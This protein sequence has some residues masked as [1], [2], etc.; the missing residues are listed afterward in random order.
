MEPDGRGSHWF[1]VSS[2]LREKSRAALGQAVSFDI[3]F[4]DEWAEPSIP[5]D[6]M[7]AIV[8][9]GLAGQWSTITTKAR[10]EWL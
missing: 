9:V 3:E 2:E 4:A 10:W 7:Y 5:E 6:I 1:E 8:K